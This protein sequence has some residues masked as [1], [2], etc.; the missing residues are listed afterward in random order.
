MHAIIYTKDYCPYCH[1]AL[2]TLDELGVSYENIDVTN[3]PEKYQEM[4]HRTGLFTV[5]Q[6]FW[7]IGGSDELHELLDKGKLP[8]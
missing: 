6:I 7:H 2:K 4:I 1:Q 8:L 3:D 5:P